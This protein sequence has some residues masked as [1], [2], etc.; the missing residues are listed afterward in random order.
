MN[1]S[2]PPSLEKRFHPPA[3]WQWGTFKNAGGRAIRYGYVL[4]ENAPP[5]SVVVGLQGLSEF[6]EKYF[7]TAHTL[8]ARNMGFFMMDWQGQ[9][10]S[11]RPLPDPHRRHSDSFDEDIE[12][13]RVFMTRHVM[14]RAGNAPLAMLAHSMGANIGLRFL[15]RHPAGHGF[16]CAA[17]SAPM[18]GIHALKNLPRW[19]RHGLTSGFLSFLRHTYVFGGKGWTP[20]TDENRAEKQLTADPVRNAVH[21]SWCLHDPALQVGNV[22]FGWLRAAETSCHKL[23]TDTGMENMKIPCLF[24]LAGRE[25]LVDNAAARRL[26]ARIAGAQTLELPDSLHEILMERDGIRTR[27]LDAFLNLIHTSTSGKS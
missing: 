22:T 16:S 25:K 17:F 23:Q 6:C 20:Q 3:G 1:D 14:P 15:L 19:I 7:E 2:A 18:A 11:A 8:L 21:D 24:A 10:K 13:F 4:P 27:F 9:G 12:D 26:A 5:A